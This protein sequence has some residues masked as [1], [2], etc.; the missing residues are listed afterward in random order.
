MLKE[1]SCGAV[2]CHFENK[3]E[4]QVLLIKHRSGGHWSFPK[5]HVE[6][7][8]SEQET[9]LREIKE[10]TG[11]NVKLVNGF[12][13]AVTYNPKPNVHKEV[14]YFMAEANTKQTKIQEEEI[15]EAVWIEINKVTDMV[16]FDN[17]KNLIKGIQQFIPK[18]KQ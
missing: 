17:D 16:T 12:R 11:L 15:S 5:G 13:Q 9:A 10:E 2:V 18:N 7:G 4:P 6:F 14:V 3:M 8:E 1:K